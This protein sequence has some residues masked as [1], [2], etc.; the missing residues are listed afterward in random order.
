MN[1]IV[2]CFIKFNF[3][4]FDVYILGL[5][6]VC[7]CWGIVSV[8]ILGGLI[9][10][11]FRGFLVVVVGLVCGGFRYLYLGGLDIWLVSVYLIG[12][13]VIYFFFFLVRF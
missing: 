11:L 7:E 5:V 8:C 1:L 10:G 3:I 4:W 2:I 13:I 12:K 9:F 6:V